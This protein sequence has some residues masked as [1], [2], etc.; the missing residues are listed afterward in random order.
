MRFD[1]A[2]QADI[3]NGTR[4]KSKAAHLSYEDSQ[5]TRK[6]HFSNLDTLRRTVLHFVLLGHFN[7][8]Q[9]PA[10][11]FVARCSISD[12][13]ILNHIRGILQLPI[14]RIHKLR[15]KWQNMQNSLQRLSFIRYLRVRG[16]DHRP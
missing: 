13:W 7:Q 9:H 11:Q 5:R 8:D 12:I 6:A 3:D 2:N 10:R 16:L 14:F 15:F 1:V 4:I